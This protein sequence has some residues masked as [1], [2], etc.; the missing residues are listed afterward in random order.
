MRI[1]QQASKHFG[2][3]SSAMLHMIA[4]IYRETLRGTI[5]SL[6]FSVGRTKGSGTDT[7][8]DGKGG[9]KSPEKALT[10]PRA[11]ESDHQKTVCSGVFI[12]KYI[13]CCCFPWVRLWVQDNIALPEFTSD[14]WFLGNTTMKARLC[15]KIFNFQIQ[16][17]ILFVY[18][19]KWDNYITVVG[20]LVSSYMPNKY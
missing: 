11:T 1:T 7:R 3:Y 5:T 13:K 4:H 6:T 12:Y 14:C 18:I 2:V 20:S 8:S 17:S 9:G 16:I 19:K 10:S 15:T